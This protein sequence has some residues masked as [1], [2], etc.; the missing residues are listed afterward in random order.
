MVTTPL[1]SL[2]RRLPR[3]SCVISAAS[4]PAM[5][6]HRR[7]RVARPR[8]AAA[9]EPRRWTSRC[10]IPV[11]PFVQRRPRR[12]RAGERARAASGS[13]SRPRPG[14]APAAICV[15]E[16]HPVHQAR[17]PSS[18]LLAPDAGVACGQRPQALRGNGLPADAAETTA[19]R[20]P[21]AMPAARAC[22]IARSSRPCSRSCMRS[23]A[24]MRPAHG[25]QRGDGRGRLNFQPRGLYDQWEG[26]HCA[27]RALAK[28]GVAALQRPC[29]FPHGSTGL[30]RLNRGKGWMAK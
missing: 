10:S 18:R 6:R 5:A 9:R 3:S 11:E 12:S 14:S 30:R 16:I 13:P 4:R 24:S 29:C 17:P 23:T 15:S 20:T 22:R 7:D 28:R 19:R 2:D 26:P 1:E 21:G 8:H 25:R 27:V